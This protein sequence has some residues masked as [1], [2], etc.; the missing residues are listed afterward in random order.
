VAHQFTVIGALVLREL[1]IR[2]G[3]N[4][5]G[6]LWMIGE[7]LMLAGVISGI[8]A[9][10]PGHYGTSIPPGAFTLLGY[11]IYIIFRGT[12]NRA[13]SIVEGNATLLYHRAISVLNIS[14]ARVVV[15]A[16]GAVS[17]LIILTCVALALNMVE[18]P[19]RPLYLFAGIGWMVWLSFALGLNVSAITFERSTLGRMVHPISYFMLPASGGWWMMDWLT[20]TLRDIMVWNPMAIIF[21][22]S[23]YGM[24]EAAPDTYLYGGYVTTWCAIFTYT[25]LLGVRR[26]RHR[27][28][29][30]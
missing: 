6:Y 17:A 16:A 13:E 28:H 4:N 12:F 22:Y 25:G 9:F 20:P 23:R 11:T 24:F 2:F 29:L 26:L 15:E 7:P 5:V 19:P 18:L 21:E 27:I 8:H 14:I 3:R 30:S 1:H 10:Q